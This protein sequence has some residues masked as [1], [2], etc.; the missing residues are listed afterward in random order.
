MDG[1]QRREW[2]ME[3]VVGGGRSQAS[4]GFQEVTES[5]DQQ[6]EEGEKKMKVKENNNEEL[7]LFYHHL[8]PLSLVDKLVLLVAGIFLVPIRSR[9]LWHA[10][11]FNVVYRLVLAVLVM[12]SAWLVSGLGLMFRDK[13]TFESQPQVKS[14]SYYN[15]FS[16][17]V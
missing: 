5:K 2:N 9:Q 8:P 11:S 14:L 4:N 15:D 16:A 6:V 1:E 13:E 3:E 12:L 17:T 10:V 7:H